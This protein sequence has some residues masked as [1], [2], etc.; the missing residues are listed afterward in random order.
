M[1]NLAICQSWNE[2]SVP[3]N[4]PTIKA[5]SRHDD[6]WIIAVINTSG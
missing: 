2:D 4:M 6:H 3:L 5:D 1:V